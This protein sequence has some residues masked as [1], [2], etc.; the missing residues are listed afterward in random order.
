MDTIEKRIQQL[1][2]ETAELN[3]Q[4]ANT[5]TDDREKSVEL[6]KAIR[7]LDLE[8]SDLR[9]QIKTPPER[10]QYWVW[11]TNHQMRVQSEAGQ[12]MYAIFTKEWL[13]ETR[14][15]E[16]QIDEILQIVIQELDLDSDFVMGLV[17]AEAGSDEWKTIRQSMPDI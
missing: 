12:D 17:S 6:M 2:T 7:E 16:P 15:R 9:Y 1:E 5:P 4:L 3:R 10:E 13:E 14:A 8:L 11:A